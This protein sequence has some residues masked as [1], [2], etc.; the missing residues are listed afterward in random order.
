MGG[1]GS[2]ENIE[3]RIKEI[4][5]QLENELLEEDESGYLKMRLAKLAGGVAVLRVGGSTEAEMGERKDRV[6]DALNATQA[7]IEEGIVP[8]GGVALVRS[9]KDLKTSQG[10]Q[11]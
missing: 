1:A 6:E 7:A 8:G 2:S 3:N 9:V 5:E 10:S 4:K 11:G